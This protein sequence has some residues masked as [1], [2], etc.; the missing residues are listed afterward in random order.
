MSGFSLD[1]PNAEQ[2]KQEVSAQ[3]APSKEEKEM[4]TDAVKEK[5]DQIMAVDLDSLSERREFIQVIETFGAD[6]VQQSQSKNSILQKR[7]G[8]FS[9]AGGESGEIAKGLEELS[10]KIRDLDP[11]S[12]DFTKTGVL[13]R[14][15]NPIRRYFERYKTADAEIASI[16]KSLDKGKSILKNDNTTLEI[17]Q[18]SMRDLTKQLTQKIELGSQLDNHLKNAVEN[19]KASNEPSERIQFVES[20]IIFPLEQRLMDFQQLLAVNQQG[21][22]AM[23]VI[24]KNNLE[25]IRAVDRAQSVTVTALRVAVTVAGALYNQKIVLEK[26]QMLN[27]TTNQMIASTA[28]LLKEQ[29]AAIQKESINAN[30]SPDTLKQAFSDT[31]SALN[32]ITAYKTKALP[33]MER[34][35]QEFYDI[36]RE[37]ERQLNSMEKSSNMKLWE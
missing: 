33:Q 35:I 25:L 1:L 8:D 34:T 5:A 23:E 29:G 18:A 2:I 31:L 7:M 9:K 4:I 27:E 37:G 15:F 11:S 13:G 30:I 24:R 3:L 21:I 32:D 12:L 26:V 10:I 14:L 22:I 16:V 19:A 28:K 17:E 6:V 20:E 36:A